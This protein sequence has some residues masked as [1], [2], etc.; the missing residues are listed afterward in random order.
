MAAKKKAPAKKT[1]A[2]GTP[3]DRILDAG[4]AEAAAVGWRHVSMEGIAARAGLGL[5]EVVLQVPNKV[6]LLRG[7]LDR[8]D[9]LTLSPVKKIDAEDSP[10]DRLFE[11]L[12]RRF[13][14]INADRDGYKAV[15]TGVARDPAAAVASICRLE[16]SFVAMLEGAGISTSG[17]K[18]L[19]RV[20]GLKGVALAGLRAWMNDDSEDLAK[21][22]A[23]LDRALERAEKAAG[24]MTLRPRKKSAAAAA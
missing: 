16:R 2:E 19:I 12:M 14:A 22:M 17:L 3:L 15:M 7:L 11:I 5:G 18:G 1:A 9:A 6:C 23:A 20:Q 10:R 21:T 8:V 4:L 13:D 24:M